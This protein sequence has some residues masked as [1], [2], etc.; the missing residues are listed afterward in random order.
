M[1]KFHHVLA[2]L[3][4][5]IATEVRNLLMNFPAGNPYDVVKETLIKKTTLSEQW[6]LQKLLSVE[7]LWNQKLTHLLCKMQQL[8]SDEADAMDLSLLRRLFLQWLPSNGRM[9][10]TSTAKKSN[11]QELAEMA[12]SVMEVISLSIA[13]VA[14]PQGTEVGELKGEVSSLRRQISDLQATRRCK[15]K[16]KSN[17]STQSQSHSP[18]HCGVCWYWY[19]RCFRDSA[20][21][22]IPLCTKQGNDRTS[23]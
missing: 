18:L 1:T 3:S 20:W 14:T 8:L 21:E 22:C 6:W 9:I 4:Q 10:L 2:I 23:S 19:H 11:L 16:S 15:S 13:M 12:D 5:D 7:D 17:R